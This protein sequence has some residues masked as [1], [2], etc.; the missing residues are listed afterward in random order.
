M[1]TVGRRS[2]GPVRIPP[3]P[4]DERTPEQQEVIDWMV[5]GPTVNIYETVGRFPDLARAQVTLGRTLRS[6]AIPVREREILILRTGWNC[7]CAYEF[8]QHRRLATEIGMDESDL[9]RIQQGPDAAGWDPFEATLC[10]AADQLHADG[11]IGDATWAELDACYDGRQMTE[12]PMVVGYYHLVSFL[13]NSLGVQL[14]DGA[15]SFVPD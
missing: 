13:L 14:E 15:E 10:R 5:V 8:A 4:E 2:P 1:S 6:G 9:R 12:V 3:V 11:L 7:G